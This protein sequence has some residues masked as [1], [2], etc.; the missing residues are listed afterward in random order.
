MI[1]R[2]VMKLAERYA[3]ETSLP[4]EFIYWWMMQTA[5]K[6]GKHPKYLEFVISE[7]IIFVKG[8][9]DTYYLEDMK[10]ITRKPSVL[11]GNEDEANY[12]EGRILERQERMEY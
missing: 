3:E 5:R 1:R 12:W 6:I 8:F 7:G 9:R 2:E 10:R 11:I 4:A